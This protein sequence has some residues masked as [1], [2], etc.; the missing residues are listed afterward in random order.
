M[1]LWR[2]L[3]LTAFV[4][5]SN[6]SLAGLLFDVSGQ[7]TVGPLTGESLTG[8]F[9]IDETAFIGTGPEEFNLLNG[10]LLELEL[11]FN[12][13]T[14]VPIQAQNFP[15][16]PLVTFS[17]GNFA[18]LAFVAIPNLG[19]V[20]INT[21]GSN[22]IVGSPTSDLAFGAFQVTPSTSVPTP[23]TLALLGLGLL[24]LSRRRK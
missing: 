5:Y 15:I 24:G 19:G 17:N 16:E 21:F 4:S 7:A 13:I 3:L 6:S 8:F 2:I 14:Y 11:T 9:E 18:G 20:G 12:G 23:A 10:G 22:F 1:K